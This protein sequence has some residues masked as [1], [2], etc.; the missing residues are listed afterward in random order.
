MHAFATGDA[1][2]EAEEGAHGGVFPEA[3]L[4][5][6]EALAFEAFANFAALPVFAGEVI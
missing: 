4:K 2:H 6:A 1:V 5:V 3:A